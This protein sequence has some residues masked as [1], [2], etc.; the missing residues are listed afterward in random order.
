MMRQAFETLSSSAASWSK[1]SFLRVLCET[2][3]I[4]SS[5]WV[6]GSVASSNLPRRNRVAAV[7][8]FS[9][10]AADCRIITELLQVYASYS[11]AS[12]A[13][14]ARRADRRPQTRHVYWSQTSKGGFYAAHFGA[15][16]SRPSD[17][18]VLQD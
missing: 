18:R 17:P 3:V 5:P 6:V 12:A 1:E 2:A 15:R 16:S 11:I 7:S 14:S 8:L 9:G 10:S 4:G 13:L